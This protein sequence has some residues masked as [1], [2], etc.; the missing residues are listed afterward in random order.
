MAIRGRIQ[1]GNLI[2]TLNASGS[3]RALGRGYN[4][5]GDRL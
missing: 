2:P 5:A 1:L 4:I 3:S